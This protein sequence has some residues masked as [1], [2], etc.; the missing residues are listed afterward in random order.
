ML[1]FLNQY[2]TILYM[3]GGKLNLIYYIE[4]GLNLV[5]RCT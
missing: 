2:K 1:V 4:E 3:S 5:L